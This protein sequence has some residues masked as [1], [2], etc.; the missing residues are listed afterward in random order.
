MS[1]LAN[2]NN[3]LKKITLILGKEGVDEL[4]GNYDYL[5]HS[6]LIQTIM[7]NDEDEEEEEVE[8][9]SSE[10]EKIPLQNVE[11]EEMEEII[12]FCK[13][14]NENPL[15]E[16]EKPIKSDKMEENVSDKWYADFIDKFDNDKLMKILL[17]AN[18][19][20]IKSLINLAAAKIASQIKD[21]TPKEIRER[22]GIENDFTKEEQE[23]MGVET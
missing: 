13:Y 11:K 18:Y 15:E 16:I 20:D 10:S 6:V 1:T 8:S 21:K 9:G 7:N 12:I 3:E 5:K 22:F 14:Y 23:Q 4:E 17:A 19:M 2:E